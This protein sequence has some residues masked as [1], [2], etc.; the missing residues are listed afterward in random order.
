VT[1]FHVGLKP[2][3]TTEQTDYNQ[4][5]LTGKFRTIA[6]KENSMN[7]IRRFVMSLVHIFLFIMKY[8]NTREHRMPDDRTK[9]W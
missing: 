5:N 8:G 4:E 2:S 3:A 9:D 6:T 1:D 7:I